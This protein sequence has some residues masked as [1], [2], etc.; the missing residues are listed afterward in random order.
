MYFKS[1]IPNVTYSILVWGNCRPSAMNSLNSI[2]TRA[3]CIISN[4]QQ[5]LV[6]DICLSKSNWLPLSYFGKK[7]VLMSIHKVYFETSCQSV[8]EL[9][10]KKTTSRTTRFPNQFNII[11]FKSDTGRNTLQYRGPVI[12]NFL[13]RLPVV[14]VSE[15]FNSCKQMLKKHTRDIA[16]FSFSKEAKLIISKKD[17]FIYFNF[18][19]LVLYYY[20]N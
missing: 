14:K 5:S 8:C 13:N 7:S 19:F 12:W 16:G 2:H 4:L 15:N 17:Y 3:S 6:D 18:L 1:I 11:R 9:L 10:S 20:L